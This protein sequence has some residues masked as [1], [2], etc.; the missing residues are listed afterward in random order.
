MNGDHH[1]L[2]FTL[3]GHYQELE[4]LQKQENMMYKKLTEKQQLPCSIFSRDS[5]LLC[6][7][8]SDT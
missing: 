4:L 5:I 1:F 2:L 3:N 6:F 8:F 7:L